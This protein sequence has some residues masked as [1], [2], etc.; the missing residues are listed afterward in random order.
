MIRQKIADDD[1][2]ESHEENVSPT[3]AHRSN[4]T[5]FDDDWSSSDQIE[6]E[7]NMTSSPA[8]S[9]CLSQPSIPSRPS[10]SLTNL[11]KSR[12][13]ERAIPQRPLYTN[14]YISSLS[15]ISTLEPYQSNLPKLIEKSR[16]Y[17][18]YQFPRPV[19]LHTSAS[20]SLPDLYGRRATQVPTNEI[21][22][23]IGNLNRSKDVEKKKVRN[24][25]PTKLLPP[26]RPPLFIPT[27]PE[28]PRHELEKF[29][30]RFENKTFVDY[31][32]VFLS[33]PVI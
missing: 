5:Q 4:S 27:T 9:L 7:E 12:S 8:A 10:L 19:Y 20:I 31:F 14:V 6:S 28:P 33:L 13:S 22:Q 15:R 11:A 18:G 25:K 23:L 29:I 3:S 32:N 24:K 30:M 16:S 26:L 21:N 2:L 1:S 17:E